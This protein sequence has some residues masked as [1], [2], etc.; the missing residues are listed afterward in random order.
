MSKETAP[1]KWHGGKNAFN[2]KLAKWIVSLMPEHVHYVEPYAGG[3]AVL[4]NKDPEGVSEVVN[5]LHRG[6][7]TFWRVLGNRRAFEFMQ[8]RLLMTPFSEPEF[9]QSKA[10]LESELAGQFEPDVAADFFIVCR[11][12]RQGLMKDFATMSQNRVRRGMN[13][14]VSSWLSAIE[15]LS[16]IHERLRRVVVFQRDALDVIRSQDGPNT[17]FYVDCPY[18]PETRSTK[19]D[20]QFEMNE[21]QHKELLGVLANLRGKFILSGYR[22]P[23]YNAAESAYGWRSA[24]FQIPNNASS[25]K[26]KD[27]K[28]EVVWMNY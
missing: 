15:G 20:Y 19:T 5:D 22:S 6:L 4:L 16:E 21:A 10:R 25:R 2:G 26:T 1:I 14:Q 11:Q 7:T 12:S 27:R 3:L 24:E 9:E 28:T 8:Q 23:L 17:L 13:E 18:L